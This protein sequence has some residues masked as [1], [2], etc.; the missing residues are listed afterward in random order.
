MQYTPSVTILYAGIFGLLLLVLSLNIFRE[1]IHIVINSAARNDDLWKR[2]ER[3]QHSFVEF[4]PICL[5]LMFLIEVHGAPGTVLHALG[6]LLLV[7][8]V[9]HAYGAGKDGAANI[10]RLIGT[11]TTYLALMI[12]SLAA[13]YYGVMPILYSKIG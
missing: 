3:A 10:L 6:M 4:V 13:I 12:S 11:Q 7:A 5:F 9:L 2:A 8:R 1:Y